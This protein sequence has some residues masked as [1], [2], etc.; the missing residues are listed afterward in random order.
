MMIPHTMDF[1]QRM[2]QGGTLIDKRHHGLDDEDCPFCGLRWHVAYL[3]KDWDGNQSSP[4]DAF[5]CPG[6]GA[7]ATRRDF[8]GNWEGHTWDKDNV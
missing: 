4:D 7:V 5:E 2:T 1:I 8:C 6:C 3:D